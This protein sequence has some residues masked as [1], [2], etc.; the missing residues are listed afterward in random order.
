[1]IPSYCNIDKILYDD[2]SIDIPY[3][4]IIN[5]HVLLDIHCSNCSLSKNFQAFLDRDPISVFDRISVSDISNNTIV[6]SCRISKSHKYLSK[7]ILEKRYK[8]F[9]IEKSIL[10]LPF[11][12]KNISYHQYECSYRDINNNRKKIKDLCE[13]INKYY[14]VSKISYLNTTYMG[15]FLDD[16]VNNKLDL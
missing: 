16:W 14:G 2:K 12:I 6:L 8:N 10:S 5:T 11:H 7:E 15:H 9:L 4:N 1:M 3:E 13:Y